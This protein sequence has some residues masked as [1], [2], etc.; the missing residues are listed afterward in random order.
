MKKIIAVIPVRKGSQRVKNKNFRKFYNKNLLVYKIL[1]LK[2]VKYVDE[3]IVNTDS[4]KAISIAKNY[5][6]SF[7]KRD[8]YF[9]S[10]KCPN[11]DFWSNVASTTNSKYILFTHCT[12]PLISVQTYQKTLKKFFSL[13]KKRFNSLNTVSEVKDFLFLKN[14]PLNFNLNQAPNSQNLPDIIK[15]NSAISILSTD[16]MK[17]NK[18]VIGDKPFFYKLD[19]FEGH[20]INTEYEFKFAEYLFKNFK[21]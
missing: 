5:G 4:D 9:A 17:N 11:S 3:I 20:D 1:T 19:Q 2:K 13:N 8:N 12:N 14:K 10:S 6:V 16:Y 7:F 21:D 18:T 15:Y